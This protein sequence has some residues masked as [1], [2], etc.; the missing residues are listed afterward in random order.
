MAYSKPY[1]AIAD[2]LALIKGRGMIVSDDALAQAYLNKI[3]YYR[4]S[5]YWYP[6]RKSSQVGG[7]TVVEDN[8]RDTTKF[9][10]IVDLYVFDKKLRLLMLDI[11][12][13]VEIALRVQIT[14][15]LGQY[16]C[17]RSRGGRYRVIARQCRGP[18]VRPR[19]RLLRGRSL[20]PCR[21]RGCRCYRARCLL[22]SVW[23]GRR[24]YGRRRRLRLGATPFLIGHH[25]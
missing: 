25:S 3:G 20:C 10:E 21:R 11:I 7:K 9:A 23:A 19:R 5:G 18:H 13:R 22:C 17:P 15:Q 1:L 14:L 24:S 16:P 12:E 8:F 2:Q 6:Y 4:L